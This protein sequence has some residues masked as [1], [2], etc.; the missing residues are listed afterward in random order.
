M[1]VMVDGGVARGGATHGVLRGL[2][3]RS[4]LR[5]LPTDGCNYDA[6][7][8]ARTCSSNGL[9]DEGRGARVATPSRWHEQVS[10]DHRRRGVSAEG[11]CKDL[12]SIYSSRDPAREHQ[13]TRR[14][15]S[16]HE[17]SRVSGASSGRGAAGEFVKAPDWADIR[18]SDSEASEGKGTSSAKFGQES[19]VLGGAH[20]WR[21]AAVGAKSK[22]GADASFSDSEASEVQGPLRSALWREHGRVGGAPDAAYVHSSDDSASLGQEAR[23]SDL[24]RSRGGARSVHGPLVAVGG[25]VEA[26][27]RSQPCGCCSFLEDSAIRPSSRPDKRPNIRGGKCRRSRFRSH[28]S[29]RDSSRGNS[30]GSSRS[31][32]GWRIPT[33]NR[34]SSSAQSMADTDAESELR[35]AVSRPPLRSRGLHSISGT[36][37]K[38]C[39]DDRP[40]CCIYLEGRC[41]FGAKCRWAHPDKVH[42]GQRVAIFCRF[43]K[44]CRLGHGKAVPSLKARVVYECGPEDSTAPCDVALGPR[45]KSTRLPQGNSFDGPPRMTSS[46]RLDVSPD[47]APESYRMK[48]DDGWRVT[49]IDCAPNQHDTSPNS[50]ST[51][52]RLHAG[53]DEERNV[54]QLACAAAPS[55]SV[56]GPVVPQ[57]FLRKANESTRAAWESDKC[58]CFFLVGRCRYGHDCRFAH[59]EAAS[60]AS[61]ETAVCSKGGACEFRHGMASVNESSLRVDR[62]GVRLVSFEGDVVTTKS[63]DELYGCA[64]MSKTESGHWSSYNRDVYSGDRAPHAWT[65]KVV[66]GPWREAEDADW[67]LKSLCGEWQSCDASRCLLN[68]TI[69]VELAPGRADCAQLM[70]VTRWYENRRPRHSTAAVEY[71]DAGHI[72]LK[73]QRRLNLDVVGDGSSTWSSADG[74]HSAP[75]VWTRMHR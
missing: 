20:I 61:Y 63:R 65:R 12:T 43:G 57:P 68:H 67:A 69:R 35:H 38:A 52:S 28:G 37:L 1:E 32:S 17:R 66:P 58:C 15:N 21:G 22:D 7:P 59:P 27:G 5:S 19:L 26:S 4:F 39:M 55:P 11:K 42:A 24:W 75:K 14:A 44:L 46:S 34:A 49:Q 29:S 73:A 70:C 40:V 51:T 10:P 48:A 56:R 45:T 25:E 16:S 2:G 3:P 41:R 30:R 8:W 9:T 13:G 74:E 31:S 50:I 62:M 18:C 47:V 71:S 54:K 33:S 36:T 60:I 53:T 64:S 6:E 72:V 23:E